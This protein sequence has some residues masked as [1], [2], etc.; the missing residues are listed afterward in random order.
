MIRPFEE[1]SSAASLC[2]QSNKK[3]F[4]LQ[5]LV[6]ILRNVLLKKASVKIAQNFRFCR[7]AEPYGLHLVFLNIVWNNWV[8]CCLTDIILL[9]GYS[10]SRNIADAYCITEV[11]FSHSFYFPCPP[12]GESKGTCPCRF[13]TSFISGSW[14]VYVVAVLTGCVSL[15]FSLTLQGEL[16]RQLLQANPI[17]ESFGNAKT[18][19]NDN[20]SRFVSLKCY[21]WIQIVL[22]V[23]A[24]L[25]FMYTFVDGLYTDP[26]CK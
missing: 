2:V 21:T 7:W 17:L 26:L 6:L 25:C 12:C 4:S 11:P 9:M 24:V 20:S 14:L 16:E 15:S 23:T 18:V 13:N 1:D 3:Y 8:Q 19:K 5:R 10:F 22:N